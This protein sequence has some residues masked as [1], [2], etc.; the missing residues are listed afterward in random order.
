MRVRETPRAAEPRRYARRDAARE[1]Q[2]HPERDEREARAH[3]DNDR[4]EERI[5]SVPSRAPQAAEDARA[6][7][8]RER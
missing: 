4:P 2:C 5:A 8:V 1:R 3:D 7:A 6:A